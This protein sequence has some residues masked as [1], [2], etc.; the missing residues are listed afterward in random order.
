MR[1]LLIVAGIAA[2]SPALAQPVETREIV[3]QCGNFAVSVNPMTGVT[4]TG[5][6]QE[7]RRSRSSIRGS[8]I[9]IRDAT[10]Y[11]LRINQDTLVYSLSRDNV[12]RESGICETL[13][14][15]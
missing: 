4:Y 1:T 15:R 3:L 6:S 5:P 9:F 10:G 8:V 2:I 7:A 12:I 11:E 14:S 13:W